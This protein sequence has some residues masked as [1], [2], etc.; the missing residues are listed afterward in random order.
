MTSHYHLGGRKKTNCCKVT[1]APPPTVKCNI[2]T[3]DIDPG[4]CQIAEES[5]HYGEFLKRDETGLNFPTF[6]K[7]GGGKRNF[8]VPITSGFIYGLSRA[9]PDRFEYM[10]YLRNGMRGL[11]RQWYQMGSRSCGDP[12]LR[13]TNFQNN[14]NAPTGT[15]VEHPCPVSIL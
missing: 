1:K 9:Q 2:T 10:N 14:N 15:H 5:D 12:N 8:R 3:C 4:L 13:A 11:A 6:E 7:R